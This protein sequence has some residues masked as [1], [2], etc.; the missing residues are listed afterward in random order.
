MYT[1]G[2]IC[3]K[4]I[5]GWD[6]VRKFDTRWQSKRNPQG[7]RPLGFFMVKN[8]SVALARLGIDGRSVWQV[9]NF[10]RNDACDKES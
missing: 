9:G 6:P 4:N 10:L 5:S 1:V 3:D 8:L 7:I 2:D